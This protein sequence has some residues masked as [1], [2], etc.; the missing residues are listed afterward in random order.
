MEQYT[1]R[2]IAKPTAITT[3]VLLTTRSGGLGASWLSRNHSRCCRASAFTAIARPT[4]IHRSVP[5]MVTASF[6]RQRTYSPMGM[7]A[8]VGTDALN[9]HNGHTT[10]DNKR[11]VLVCPKCR[12]ESKI[13]APRSKKEKHRHR[14]AIESSKAAGLP[15]PPPPPPRC[16]PC[17]TCS[18]TGLCSYDD[19]LSTPTLPLIESDIEV[20]IIGGGIGG[21]ALALALQHRRIPCTVYE[22]DSSFDE[23]S[24]G[25]GLTMQQGAKALKALGFHLVPSSRDGESGEDVGRFGIH[26]KRHVVHTSD[27]T[28]VGE[29]G[30]K[31][32]GRP[33]T[34]AD[35][36]SRQNAH[37][38][39]QE[40]RRM[41]MEKIQPGTIQWGHALV[42]YQDSKDGLQL[43]FQKR[44]G[45]S[46][47][48]SVIEKTAT[49]LVGADGIRSAVRRQKIG[50]EESPL[51]Y[52]GCIVILG[53]S[54]SPVSNLTD[55]ETVFQTADGTT[56][57]YAMPF[58]S[59]GEETATASLGGKNVTTKDEP[60]ESNG[61]ET[62]WQ[63]SFPMKEEDAIKLS[64]LGLSA[65]KSEALARCGSWHHP[66]PTLLKMTPETLI[67]G[68]PVYD[69]ELLSPDLLR[70]GT[71]SE[72][73]S[74]S[75]KDDTSERDSSV[76]LIGDAA[77][78]MSPFK[79]QGANQALLDAVGLARVLYKAFSL[80]AGKKGKEINVQNST[81]A[82]R[83]QNS[84]LAYEKDM[85][86]RSATKVEASARA[87]KFLHSDIAI[88]KGNFPR[89]TAA[90][91]EE[92]SSEAAP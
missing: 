68:Y 29:W 87:A 35:Q 4:I 34:K 54:T 63:L 64:Q 22:R 9:S 14:L 50:D 66:I 89:G 42:H 58:S 92:L 74:D 16:Q 61:G 28:V 90:A 2:R 17:K 6:K 18:G 72:L 5:G 43:K 32:W 52:L 77:H 71:Q 55:G 3:L 20:A 31:V 78:P 27:G 47:E 80:P 24:Q 62:M 88:T 40:L 45:E 11:V 83:I 26:S 41:L 73:R 65:L 51:S 84:L 85:L 8:G 12:G 82:E 79:G 91:K 69:R 37:V 13:R 25:Y 7:T 1:W 67:S 75:K 19:P 59:V 76:T 46:S 44:D 86:E 30:M 36:A 21:F 23:R 60:Y 10:P 49:V 38:P 56:R 15:E 33:D 39:R 53:I 57:L 81:R 48:G 70:S